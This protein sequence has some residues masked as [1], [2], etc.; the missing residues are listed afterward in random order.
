MED[1]ESTVVALLHDVAEDTDYTLEDIAAMG[2]SRNVTEALALL[3]HDET[4]PYMEYVKALRNNPIAR[5]VKLAD[6]A[7]HAHNAAVEARVR[8]VRAFESRVL[9]LSATACYSLNM[10]AVNGSDLIENGMAP[11]PAVGRTLNSL[12]QA[13]MEERLPNEKSA[14]LA[15]VQSLQKEHQP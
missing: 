14:L 7:A 4:V 5:R 1:E 10:L 11:G 12:L 15:Y 2:F 9:E 8:D 6:L 13:V 3:T